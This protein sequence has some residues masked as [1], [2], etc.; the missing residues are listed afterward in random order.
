MI[1][2]RVFFV[3]APHIAAVNCIQRLVP[4][5]AQRTSTSVVVRAN[6]SA[7]WS[8]LGILRPGP[9]FRTV[10][11]CFPTRLAI[12][13]AAVCDTFLCLLH[14]S[15]CNRADLCLRA[16]RT[17]KRLCFSMNALLKAP[18]N[19]RQPPS[20]P[21]LSNSTTRVR[22]LSSA[23]CNT[24]V[25]GRIFVPGMFAVAKSVRVSTKY[26]TTCHEHH[27]DSEF[28]EVAT[29]RTPMIE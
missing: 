2:S 24:P 5:F 8:V 28:G 6:Q 4:A 12:G 18:S 10:R 19:V 23:S 1:P 26:E 14:R 13:R 15:F 9:R 27:I 29:F 11:I 25:V 17:R 3:T 7:I 21:S 20:A 22:K 16:Q